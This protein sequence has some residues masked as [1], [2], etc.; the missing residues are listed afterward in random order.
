MTEPAT[1][2]ADTLVNAPGPAAAS[3]SGAEPSASSQP[4][5]APAS[6]QPAASGR[7]PFKRA[8]KIRLVVIGAVALIVALAFVVYPS[9]VAMTSPFPAFR[10]K[11]YSPLASVQISNLP[12][13]STPRVDAMVLDVRGTRITRTLPVA[14]PERKSRSGPRSVAFSRV[15][16]RSVTLRAAGP[17]GSGVGASCTTLTTPGSFS[18]ADASNDATVSP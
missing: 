5:P 8:T 6:G 17:D 1:T 7:R 12:A 9:D 11:R 15:Q 14:D 16:P 10:W 18:A 3:G 13:I 4:A 2:E